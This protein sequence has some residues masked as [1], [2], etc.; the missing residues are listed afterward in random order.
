MS[1]LTDRPGGGAHYAGAAAADREV[2]N[3]DSG[4][5]PPDKVL[6]CWRS[7]RACSGQRKTKDPKTCGVF[8]STFTVGKTHVSAL[9]NLTDLKLKLGH[10][11][12]KHTKSQTKKKDVFCVRGRHN[13]GP[14]PVQVWCPVG[15][16][17]VE[18]LCY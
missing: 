17:S 8:E 10:F 3:Q 9:N 4:D 6:T 7:L 16:Y 14:M 1:T 15:V 13:T 11:T 12:N 2:L 5:E 18:E